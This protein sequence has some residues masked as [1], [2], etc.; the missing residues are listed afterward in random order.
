MTPD[1]TQPPGETGSAAKRTPAPARR[2][3]PGPLRTVLAAGALFLVTFEF[4]AFQLSSGRDPAVGAG[5]PTTTGQ[6]PQ[7]RRVIRTRVVTDVLPPRG[8]GSSGGG[9]TASSGPAQSS[10]PA[11][12]STPAP[13]PVVT[14]SS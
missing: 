4:L 13:A 8:S 3:R 5:Q 7:V 6:R 12:A 11:P 10:S 1:Q 14:S 2:R 9:A